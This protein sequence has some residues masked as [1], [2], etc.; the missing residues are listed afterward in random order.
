MSNYF[1]GIPA[2][3]LGQPSQV[4]VADRAIKLAFQEQ[5]NSTGAENRILFSDTLD[6]A[7]FEDLINET[8]RSLRLF[9][10]GTIKM[11]VDVRAEA[12]KD[13]IDG[14]GY[15]ASDGNRTFSF[16]IIDGSK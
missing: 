3:N 16:D 11:F 9:P 6:S 14:I 2:K 15:I 12:N 13:D 8:D 1:C 5:Y 7:Y 10:S 4:C